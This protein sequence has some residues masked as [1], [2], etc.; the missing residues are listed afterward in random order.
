MIRQEGNI[1]VI[2]YFNALSRLMESERTLKDIFDISTESFPKVIAAEYRDENGKYRQF[3]YSEYRSGTYVLAGQLHQVLLGIPRG[4]IVGLKLKNS[5]IWGMMF[6]AIVMNG[7]QPFLL[8]ARATGEATAALL[9]QTDAKAIVADDGFAYVIPHFS[10]SEISSRAKDYAFAATWE[11]HVV[12]ATSGTTGAAK[13]VVFDGLNLVH[14]INAA[15]DMPDTT[16]DIMYPPTMGNLKILALIPFHHIFGF[17]AVFLWYTFFGKTIVYLD[18]LTPKNIMDTCQQFRISHI[19]AVPLFWNSVAQNVHRSALLQ[20]TEKKQLLDKIIAYQTGNISRAEAG[21]AS[22]G[23]VLR[24]LEKKVLG[25]HVRFCISGGGALSQDTLNTI[26]G[27]GY[28]LYN[29]YGLTEIGVTSVELV[30]SIQQRLRGSVGKPLHAIE[31]K[32]IPLNGNPQVG[33]LA[34]K[35]PTIHRYEIIGQ[36]K[37]PT[38]LDDGWFHTGDIVESDRAGFYWIKGRIKDIIVNANGE[39]VYPEEIESHFR[40]IDH[41]S[42]CAV[43]GIR[44]SETSVKETIVLILEADGPLDQSKIAAIQNDIKN[45]NVTLPQYMQV[46]ETLVYDGIL[47]LSSAMKVQK[48]L[49]REQLVTDSR[50]FTAISEGRFAD[51]SRYPSELIDEIIPKVRDLFSE[52][53]LLPAYKLSDAGHFVHDFGGDSL[54]Y[55]TLVSEIEEKFGITIDDKD[56]GRLAS[57]NDFVEEIANKKTIAKK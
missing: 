32:I 43:L 52:V 57:I 45:V 51:F 23:A 3:R 50:R 55:N 48:F 36:Q 19:Y 25:N 15:H 11:N 30:H 42:N 12:L 2:R 1:K 10:A 54:S 9:A 13:I 18:S 16:A 4:S 6:W 20:G 24:G 34:I 38:V 40:S 41:V 22:S 8:D 27:I 39:N 14:Q 17:V 46:E 47:P 56:F 28:P 44:K 53:L 29:G 26:N 33:E 31:Y 49:L 37:L 7:C 35:S 21:F 5:P